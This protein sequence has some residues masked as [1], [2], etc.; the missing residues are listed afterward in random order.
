MHSMKVQ[1]VVAL[2]VAGAVV[3]A[4]AAGPIGVAMANGAFQ[5]NRSEVLGNASLFEGTEVKTAGASS[6]LRMNGGA[7]LEIGTDSQAKIYGKRMVLEQGAGQVESASYTMEARTLRITPD[8]QAI[9]RVQLVGDQVL[10]SSHSGIVRV[11]NAEGRLV[12]RVSPR[13][14]FYFRPQAAAPEAFDVTGCVLKIR[15]TFIMVDGTTNQVFELR[16]M[17]LAA[18]LGSRAEIKGKAETEPKAIAEAIGAIHVESSTLQAPGGCL[19]VGASVG[20]DPLPGVVQTSADL[21]KGKKKKGAA[22]AAAGGAAGGAAAAG[23]AGGAAAG[24]A[25]AAGISTG[26]LV[27]VG[28]A[29]AGGTAAAVAIAES[30]KSKSP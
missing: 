13:A 11:S 19:A 8:G 25:T 20:A 27:G 5:V 30:S 3:N 23:A 17:D 26:V 16:G 22:A 10:V 2:I 15:G 18:V 24:A 4:M 9:A 12:A 28:V 7:R 14:S 6:K 21:K 29:A 1:S